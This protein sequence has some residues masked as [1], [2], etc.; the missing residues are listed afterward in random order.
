M[1]GNSS[2]LAMNTPQLGGTRP[3][4]GW[5]G[6]LAPVPRAD[7][8]SLARVRLPALRP[9]KMSRKGSLP[10]RVCARMCSLPQ[11]PS[12][13][14]RL[15]RPAF[16]IPR[17]THR[18]ALRA[19]CALLV[20]QGRLLCA[21][22][23]VEKQDS[24]PKRH[25]GACLMRPGTFTRHVVC[26]AHRSG[27]CAACCSTLVA[28]AWSIGQATGSSNHDAVLRGRIFERQSV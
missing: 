13:P 8:R 5:V 19:R 2:S 9:Q 10:S 20:L 12:H 24:A 6:P 25:T 26:A 7:R 18:K 14:R 4:P 15:R 23:L 17:Y 28:R 3:I 22:F 1:P 27:M 11:S 21:G 16:V